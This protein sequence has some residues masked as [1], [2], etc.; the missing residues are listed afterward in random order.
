MSLGLQQATRTRG[1]MPDLLP[2][3]SL[4]FAMHTVNF[5]GL[6]APAQSGLSLCWHFGISKAV[7]GSQYMKRRYSN[8][9]VKSL[10]Q[11]GMNRRHR[12]AFHRQN[13]VS[14]VIG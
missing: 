14:S 6:A 4:D 11:S 5:C 3:R 13:W 2:A 9:L 10:P 1:L 7:E 12:S 8:V